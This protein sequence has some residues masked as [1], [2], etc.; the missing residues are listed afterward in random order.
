MDGMKSDTI[1]DHSWNLEFTS[2]WRDKN[3][4]YEDVKSELFTLIRHRRNADYKDVCL[5]YTA[6]SSMIEMKRRDSVDFR[7]CK[8]KED[9]ESPNL[10]AV[11]VHDIVRYLTSQSLCDVGMREYRDL[12]DLHLRQ[13]LSLRR[14]ALPLPPSPSNS[15]F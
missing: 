8:K 3:I 10:K 7:S 11:I 2:I 9:A 4:G 5:V 6:A 13:A 14:I 1:I 12:I 15:R